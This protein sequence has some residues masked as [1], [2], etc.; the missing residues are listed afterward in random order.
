MHLDEDAPVQFGYPAVRGRVGDAFRKEG[1][2]RLHHPGIAEDARNFLVE[3]L[4]RQAVLPGDHRPHGGGDL[5]GRDVVE[6]AARVLRIGGIGDPRR[7]RRG[8]GIGQPVEVVARRLRG[9]MVDKAEFLVDRPLNLGNN[10]LSSKGFT[11]MS[12]RSS[13]SNITSPSL[14]SYSL[15]HFFSKFHQSI[16]LSNL[17]DLSSDSKCNLELYLTVRPQL[18]QNT[19]SPLE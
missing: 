8:L 12:S 13:S 17:N 4:G 9:L 3:V 7:D 14:T 16:N 15:V 10:F 1:D 18:L 19:Y 6:V 2:H 11:V 5:F